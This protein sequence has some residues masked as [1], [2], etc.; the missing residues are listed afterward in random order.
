MTKR[1]PSPAL[2][3]RTSTISLRAALAASSFVP[4]RESGSH[5]TTDS[6]SSFP[7]SLESRCL[8]LAGPPRPPQRAHPVCGWCAL[9]LKP[10]ERAHISEPGSQSCIV[11]AFKNAGPEVFSEPFCEFLT[12]N[13]TVFHAV[14]HFIEK[15]EKAGYEEVCWPLV[16][17]W[18]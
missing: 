4:Y 17:L 7:S 9:A 18:I 8:Q 6:K 1:A 3:E 2:H 13:P 5:S 15:L 10:E 12:E 11:C 16:A 14:A